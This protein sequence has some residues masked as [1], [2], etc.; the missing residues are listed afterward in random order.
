MRL[1]SLGQDGHNERAEGVERQSDAR[2][3]Q[4]GPIPGG[5]GRGVFRVLGH[6]VLADGKSRSVLQQSSAWQSRGPAARLFAQRPVQRRSLEE[7]IDQEVVHVVLFSHWWHR[8]SRGSSGSSG[9][10]D[11]GG[12]VSRAT[13][14]EV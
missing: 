6:I 9:G 1:A 7:V 12:A 11:S 5:V 13:G 8:W 14:S 4:R 2:Q 10:A 3:R